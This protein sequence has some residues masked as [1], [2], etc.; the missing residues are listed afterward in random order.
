M[1]KKIFC[2]FCLVYLFATGKL[3]ASEA[4]VLDVEVIDKG[5][6]RYTFNVTIR[7]EDTGWDH[8]ADRWEILNLQEEIIAVRSLRHPH[9]KQESFTRSLPFVPVHQDTKEIKVRAHCSVDG[10]TGKQVVIKLPGE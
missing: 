2:L 1:K 3:N 7:H 9:M 10:F 6:N 8:Y 4:D 5:D